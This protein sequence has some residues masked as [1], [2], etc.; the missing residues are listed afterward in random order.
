MLL[1]DNMLEIQMGGMGGGQ[2]GYMGIDEE[3]NHAASLSYCSLRGGSVVS[4]ASLKKALLCPT[5]TPQ[6]FKKLHK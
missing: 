1:R 3:G 4:G 6:V 5:L 2:I